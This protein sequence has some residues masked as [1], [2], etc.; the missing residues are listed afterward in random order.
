MIAPLAVTAKYQSAA[1]IFV[2]AV[3]RRDRSAFIGF[4]VSID[5]AVRTPFGKQNDKEYGCK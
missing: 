4:G 1:R 5:D 3:V 2:T